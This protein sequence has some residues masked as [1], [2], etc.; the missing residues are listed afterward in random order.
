MKLGTATRRAVLAVAVGG[1]V[2]ASLAACGGSGGGGGDNAAASAS[3]KP[4]IKLGQSTSL[5]GALAATCAPPSEGMTTWIKYINDQGGVDGHKIALTTLD[6]AGSAATAVAN[7]RQ[8]VND[9]VSAVVGGCGS[10]AAGAMGP[11]LNSAKMPYLF[12]DASVPALANPV[13]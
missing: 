7:V 6:D 9:Q 2:S 4:D 1:M 8:F 12:P 11:A 10:T 13:S 3:S 5:T